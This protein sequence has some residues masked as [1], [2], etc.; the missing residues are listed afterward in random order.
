[1]AVL[2]PLLSS[3]VHVPSNFAKLNVSASFDYVPVTWRVNLTSASWAGDAANLAV[4]M[5]TGG[6]AD[7]PAGWQ[8]DTVSVQTPQSA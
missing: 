4:N 8:F 3:D 1:M 6:I 2:N 7:G 5:L